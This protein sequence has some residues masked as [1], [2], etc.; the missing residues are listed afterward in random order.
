MELAGKL[1]THSFKIDLFLGSKAKY[2]KMEG[3]ISIKMS[4][5]SK[6][7]NGLIIMLSRPARVGFRDSSIE[8]NV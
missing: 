1:Q 3:F 4:S 8:T 6:P 2:P 7:R 5:S